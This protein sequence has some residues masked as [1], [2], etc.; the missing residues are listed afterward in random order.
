M[1]ALDWP[2]L[3]LPEEVGGV[4]LGFVEL[5]VVVEELG[6]AV[7]PGPLLPTAT[8]F[9]ATVAELG[10]EEQRSRFL[11]AV[12][13]GEVTG[14]LALADHPA[15][16]SPAAVT[17][18]A[19][20]SGQGF[21]LQG[22]KHAVMAG[23]GVDEVAVAARL[24]GAA[25]GLEG[26][27]VFVVP[28]SD[29]KLDAATSLD[30]TRPLSTADIGG[31]EVSGDRVLG[32]PGAAGRGL[33]RAVEQATVALALE[34]VGTCQALFELVCAYALDRQQFGTPIGAFQAVKH[35]L[36]DDFVALARARALAYHAVAAIAEDAAER[37]VATAMAKAA[38]D[39]CQRR[40]CQDAIQ[41]L[42]GIGFT[43]EHDAHL[44]VKRAKSSGLL[45]GSAAEH[46]R[47]VARHLGLLQSA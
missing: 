31:V 46:R 27:A 4:G 43:W 34:A 44:Y 18:R 28:G 7:A 41:T 2:A 32:E 39:E 12:A 24:A 30:A 35:K 14:C 6:R 20:P 36:A 47:A 25:P 10:S 15:T 21:V 11:G 19:Q 23:Q 9:A 26:L 17:A 45:F 37:S 8:Q 40:V 33:V 1:V 16:W 13:R 38:A 42:G 3:A 5:A 22:T 29:L